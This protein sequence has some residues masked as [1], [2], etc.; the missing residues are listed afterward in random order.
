MV[1]MSANPHVHT[2]ISLPYEDT[3]TPTKTSKHHDLHA[4]MFRKLIFK[5]EEHFPNS[6]MACRGL[7]VGRES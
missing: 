4:S 6:P 3:V 2:R 1:Y 7:Q 5:Q